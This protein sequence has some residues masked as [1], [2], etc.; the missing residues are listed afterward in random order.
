MRCMSA[1]ARTQLPGS[2]VQCSARLPGSAVQVLRTTSG[3]ILPVLLVYYG[4]MIA[5]VQHILLILTLQQLEFDMYG[6]SFKLDSTIEFGMCGGIY[7]STSTAL[8][9]SR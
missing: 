3:T 8:F 9:L 7:Q 4:Y 2:A 6:T 1:R 5:V